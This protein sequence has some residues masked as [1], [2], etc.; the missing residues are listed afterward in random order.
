MDALDPDSRRCTPGFLRYALT[1]WHL[2]DAAP[3]QR[4]HYYYGV[5][6]TRLGRAHRP[7]GGGR[8]QPSFTLTLTQKEV[9]GKALCDSLLLEKRPTTS[10]SFS[11]S[12]ST[13]VIQMFSIKK[14]V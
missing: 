4:P 14:T 7:P 11:V 2:G 9:D 5:P 1:T 8:L 12:F 10:S 6:D 3:K 13:T